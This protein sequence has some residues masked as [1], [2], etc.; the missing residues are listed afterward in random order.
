[1]EFISALQTIGHTLLEFGWHC[2][3]MVVQAAGCTL[4]VLIGLPFLLLCFHCSCVLFFWVMV[5]LIRFLGHL[6]YNAINIYNMVLPLR[7]NAQVKHIQSQNLDL[8]IRQNAHLEAELQKSLEQSE[9]IRS[10]Q[11]SL[12]N[13]VGLLSA[14]LNLKKALVEDMNGRSEKLSQENLRLRRDFTE[15]KKQLDEL[16]CEQGETPA[17][18]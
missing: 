10:G 11:A 18:C 1:M 5:L 7:I 15:C 3:C 13:T 14:E 9:D 12:S 16:I 6:F 2:I 4:G 8:I 17:Q